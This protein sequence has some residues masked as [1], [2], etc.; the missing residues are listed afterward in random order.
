[1]KRLL[2]ISLAGAW[3]AIGMAQA[4]NV[5]TQ[6]DALASRV[7]KLEG[8]RAIK[9]LQRA[10]GYYVDRGLWGDAADLFSDGFRSESGIRRTD[11]L[12]R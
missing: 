11:G 8:T 4:Q 5:D 12:G 9:K 7:E 2:I 10:F 1:M 3:L 6:L